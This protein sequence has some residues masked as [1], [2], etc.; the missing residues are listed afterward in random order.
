MESRPTSRRKGIEKSL[1]ATQATLA[2]SQAI[3]HLG[4]WELNRLN[5]RLTWSDETFRIFG[6]DPATFVPTYDTFFERTHPED[7]AA[8]EKAYTHTV[9]NHEVFDIDHRIFMDDGTVR[10]VHER[11]KTFYGDKQVNGQRKYTQHA[12]LIAC[13]LSQHTIAHRP[14]SSGSIRA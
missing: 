13:L 6:V 4:S 10:F 12:P 8:V 3:A 9:A 11:G 2:D 7:R 14:P 5:N 1:A